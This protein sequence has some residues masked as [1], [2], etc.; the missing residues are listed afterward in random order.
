[1]LRKPLDRRTLLRGLVG[2]APVAL[3][4]PALESMMDGHGTAFAQVGGG[5][6]QGPPQRFGVW[7]FGGGVVNSSFYPSATG[8]GWTPS[9]MLEPLTPVKDYVTVVSGTDMKSGGKAHNSHRAYSV[10]NSWYDRGD[11]YGDPKHPSVDQIV[12]EAWSGKTR[13]KS[14]EIGVS[15]KR[16]YAS[17][18][19]NGGKGIQPELNP[20]RVF[21]RLFGT[22]V[23]AGGG[24]A[25]QKPLL[26]AHKSVLDATRNDALRL[27]ARLGA[28]D[29]ARVDAHQQAVRDI[30]R[31]LQSPAVAP[32]SG[33]AP[34]TC[35]KPDAPSVTTTGAPDHEELEAVSKVMSDL[36]VVGLACDLV[37]VFNFQFTSAQNHTIFWQVGLKGEF[38]PVTHGEQ[39]GGYDTLGPKA[40]AFTMKN[41]EYLVSRLKATPEGAGNLLDQTLMYVTTEFLSAPGHS[42]NN[43]PMLLVGRGGGTVKSGQHLKVPGE[44]HAKV[45]FACLKA[46]GMNVTG[47]GAPDKSC[48][49][50]ASLPGILA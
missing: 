4:L 44:N 20:A 28:S 23:P 15:R 37:R 26:Q 19:G 14:V 50:T 32:A 11:G 48:Y 25:A 33:A 47:F 43:H 18:Y 36:L 21:D 40:V 29:K 7:Y 31:Q 27:M 5:P 9:P 24:D 13:L 2:G 39:G 6:G 34:G 1:M 35:A 30:E 12:A 49:A 17:A 38:H 42:N 41:L 8:T 22:G 45:M 10:A 3:G 46:M 16:I